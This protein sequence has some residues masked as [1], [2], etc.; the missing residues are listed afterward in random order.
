M[1]N[2]LH[3]HCGQNKTHDAG[4]NIDAYGS[5]LIGNHDGQL[6]H[7]PDDDTNNKYGNNQR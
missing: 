6:E 5:Q 3:R 4:D 7:Q 2:K 1:R